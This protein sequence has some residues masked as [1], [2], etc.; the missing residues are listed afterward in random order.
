MPRVGLSRDLLSPQ[1]TPPFDPALL[2]LL[3]PGSHEWIPE[4]LDELTPEVAGR[5]EAILI[6][7][8]RVT[9]RSLATPDLSLRLIARFGVGYDQV[10]VAALTEAGVILT[11][12][13][14]AIRRPVATMA[15]TFVLALAQKLL[16]KDRLTRSGRWQERLAHMGQGVTGKTLGLIGAGGVGREIIPLARAF[17]MRVRAADPYARED[18]IAALGAELVSLETVLRESDFV[19]I[20]CPLTAETRHLIDAEKL[21]LMRPSA[22]LINVARGPIVDERALIEALEKRRIAGAA[23]DVFETEPVAPD[24]P[25]LAMDTTIVTPHALCWTDENFDGIARDALSDIAAAL[26]GQRPRFIVNP[27]VLAHPRVKAWLGPS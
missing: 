2:G 23:L 3:P 1:G 5:Y 22:Y 6:N 14:L 27:E 4:P 26:A 25:L 9:A 16:I 17:A 8:P 12:T 20:A 11:N 18:E 15:M 13:P 10:D 21:A 7:T 24:N 19:V